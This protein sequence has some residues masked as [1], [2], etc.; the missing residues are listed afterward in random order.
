[1]VEWG[2][3]FDAWDE[4]VRVQ[5]DWVALYRQLGQRN[6]LF[7]ETRTLIHKVLSKY[8]ESLERSTS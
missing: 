1:M 8:S 4:D 3:D 7:L 5:L 6:G 2:L